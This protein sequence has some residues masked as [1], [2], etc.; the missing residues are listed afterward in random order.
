MLKMRSL[1][2]ASVTAIACGAFVNSVV[3][4]DSIPDYGKK[5]LSAGGRPYWDIARD[6]DRKPADILAFSQIKPGMVVVDLVPGD[7]YYTR[8]LA[9]LV[10]P[11][12]KVFAIV[13]HGGGGGSR[14]S[15]MSQREGKE[16]AGI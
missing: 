6:G 9:K 2:L 15:R 4:A 8:M 12:G 3:A 1:L 14:S 13:P 5:T 11:K 16:P 10:G 7:A